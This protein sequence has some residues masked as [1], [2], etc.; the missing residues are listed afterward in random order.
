[1]RTLASRRSCSRA[2]PRRSIRRCA[3]RAS[4][5]PP[6]AASRRSRC[7]SAPARENPER[8]AYRAEY[9]RV[10]DLR[11]RNGWRRPRRCARAASSR[12]PRRSTAACRSTTP[13]NARARAGLQQLDVDARHRALVAAA[14][15]LV[16]NEQLPRGAGRAAPGAGREP[17]AAR[18]AAPAAPDRRAHR[19]AGDRHAAP[20]DR[21]REPIS[22]E[23]RDVHAARGVRHPH[24]QHRASAS[25]STATCAPTSAPPSCCATPAR[26]ADP[27]GAAP[28][29]SSSR[30]C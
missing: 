14:E 20:E 17:A 3:R 1:M 4:T 11:S 18:R 24:A 16:K 7:S 26:G 12:P 30:R 5:S 2:A 29:T 19:Q 22:L 23:L 27:P 21:R 13:S 10:R 15:Q 28:P 9:L 8:L 6:G 25:C